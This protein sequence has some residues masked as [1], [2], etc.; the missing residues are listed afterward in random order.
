MKR[1]RGI[2]PLLSE[3]DRLS[4][5]RAVRILNSLLPLVDRVP[6][7]ELLNKV[8]DALD[9]RAIL[10][11][12]DRSVSEGAAS[13]AGG[14]LWRNLDKLLQDAQASQQ[15]NVR[16]FLE[17]LQ[18]LNDAGAREGEAPSE[19]EG[20]VRLMTIHKAK[21]LEFGLVVL[22]NAGSGTRNTG[23][24]IYLSSELGVTFK[25]DPPPM[26]YR[27]AKHIDKDQDAAE[28]LRLLYVAMTRAKN[29]LIIS[30]HAVENK[31]GE[32]L[33]GAWAGK[34]AD[35]A[36]LDSGHYQQAREAAFKHQSPAGFPLRVLCAAG[37]LP[38][39]PISV[40]PKQDAVSESSLA[41]L[42][43]PL[44]GYL[45]QPGDED[46]E[47]DRE[48]HLWRASMQEKDVPGRVLGSLVHQ[49]IAAWIFP[50]DP[51]LQDLLQAESFNAGL[52][53]ESQREDAVQR[54]VQL[55]ERL[56]QHPLWQEISSAPERFAE[57]PYTY[58]L[59]GK[60]ASGKIDLLYR[61]GERWHILD[62][63]T[64]PVDYPSRR[65]ALLRQYQPQ[66]SRYRAAVRGLLGVDASARL[67]F[68]DDRGQISLVAV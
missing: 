22:A 49:A 34:L 41:P 44:D 32:I 6:V 64:D 18:T 56:Q 14:R 23:E 60:P 51:G 12:A 68:L 54:A 9:Y 16:D 63:K 42:Y 66:I 65:E 2:S 57:I 25:L 27:L 50:G 1:C 43:R 35:A 11:T 58:Q 40:P 3:S 53:S 39:T 7:A 37:D 36:G 55:L 28:E 29:K 20:A 30:A 48:T 8:V 5:E 33:A 45:E 17:M 67:C 10:A 24:Q 46:H 13:R 61:S 4:A 52:A 26:L 38:V 19:A 59:Y 21:G 15:V 31:K 47:T 62:F